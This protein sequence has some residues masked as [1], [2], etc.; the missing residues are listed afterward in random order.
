M[1]IKTINKK[2]KNKMKTITKTILIALLAVIGWSG[3]VNAQQTTPFAI[4]DA[5]FF[6]YLIN[7][8][9]INTDSDG[10][11][12]FI[13]IAEATGFAGTINV[14]GLSIANLTGISAFTALTYLD[15]YNNQLTS[16]NVSG[17]TALT[18]LYCDNNLLTSLN[19][20]ANTA[21]DGLNCSFNS[22]TSLNVSAN[23]ALT[24]LGCNNNQL[25]SLNVSANTDLTGL[26][27]SD[28]QLTSL[29]M[30]VRLGLFKA[31]K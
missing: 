16:L 21:L 6:N 7:N 29:N 8:T 5:H 15:C 9:A 14:Q 31:E 24:R 4:P 27:C 13:S 10:S 23:T 1:K 26:N 19:V 3:S 22:L 12:G 2:T 18:T 25:T 20:S 30:Q 28:N 17:N 11:I